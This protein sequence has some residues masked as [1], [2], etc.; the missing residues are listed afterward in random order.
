MLRKVWDE[1][2]TTLYL[3]LLDWFQEKFYKDSDDYMGKYAARNKFR[4]LGMLCKISEEREK[5]KRCNLNINKSH[6]YNTR[7]SFV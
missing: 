7:K 2:A 1:N 6:S 4:S 5:Q 3:E